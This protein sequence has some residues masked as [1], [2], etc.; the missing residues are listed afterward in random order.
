MGSEKVFSRREMLRNLGI[1]GAVVWVAPVLSSLPAHAETDNR[2]HC[3]KVCKGQGTGCDGG[4]AQCSSQESCP[5]EPG[6]GAYCFLTTEGKSRCGP[7][8]YCHDATPCTDS[9]GCGPG[10]VCITF[11]HCDGCTGSVA[12]CMP[13]C[14]RCKLDGAGP[15]KPTRRLGRTAAGR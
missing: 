14:K 12:Y 10:E 13:K 2:R 15:R 7:D 5:G 8:F 11:N 9:T 3:R 1:A 4:F 6:D